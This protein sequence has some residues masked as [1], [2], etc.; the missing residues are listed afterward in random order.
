[1]KELFHVQSSLRN[2]C[3]LRIDNLTVNGG[4]K[5]CRWAQVEANVR[6]CEIVNTSDTPET[7]V[8]QERESPE[9][10]ET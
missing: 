9:N 4:E 10:H 2:R 7:I 3:H 6:L 8:M 5:V 1:M